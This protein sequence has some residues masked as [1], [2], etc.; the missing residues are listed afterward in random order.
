MDKL[1]YTR[2][3]SL[4]LCH[5]T[6]TSQDS[7]CVFMYGDDTPTM[8]L[9]SLFYHTSPTFYP[10]VPDQDAPY[11]KQTMPCSCPLNQNAFFFPYHAHMQ[12]T[13]IEDTSKPTDLTSFLLQYIY[14]ETPP[15]DHI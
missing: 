12:P 10:L 14:N 8:A 2:S 1:P 11:L 3:S 4:L 7:I 13:Y 6:H 9:Q 5:L 15:C